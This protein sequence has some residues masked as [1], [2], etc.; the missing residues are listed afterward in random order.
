MNEELIGEGGAPWDT[1]YTMIF[2]NFIFYSI[3]TKLNLSYSLD[4]PASIKIHPN[5]LFHKI[6]FQ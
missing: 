4:I 6:K 3:F 2:R 5:V 1:F